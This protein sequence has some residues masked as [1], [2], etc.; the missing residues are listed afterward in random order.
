MF[1]RGLGPSLRAAFERLLLLLLP[2]L[3]RPLLVPPVLLLRPSFV[4][5]LLL[6]L[7]P[8]SRLALPFCL[9]QCACFCCDSC[10]SLLLHPFCFLLLQELPAL[11]LDLELFELPHALQFHL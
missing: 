2:P 9:L 6:L 4:E 8:L 3:S 5:L 7:P 10:R 11:S 1:C